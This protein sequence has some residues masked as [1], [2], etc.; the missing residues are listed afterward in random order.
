MTAAAATA[1]GRW[2]GSQWSERCS[3][4]RLVGRGGCRLVAGRLTLPEAERA[5]FSPAPTCVHR[6]GMQHAS[7]RSRLA[8]YVVVW[9]CVTSYSVVRRCESL[10]F[11]LAIRR[12]FSLESGGG[13]K[14]RGF[15]FC[16]VLAIWRS[17]SLEGGGGFKVVQCAAGL[18]GEE[19]AEQ[20]Q[21]CWWGAC[22][23]ALG[24]GVR[25]RVGFGDSR[26]GGRHF[27]CFFFHGWELHFFFYGRMP[28][29]LWVAQVWVFM[30][31]EEKRLDCDRTL[32]RVRR[33]KSCVVACRDACPQIRA[34]R[35][36][37]RGQG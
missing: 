31:Q 29:T 6:A 16:F 32:V 18:Q 10:Y 9:R 33:C 28:S 17:F 12:S 20:Q 34:G 14:E 22:R 26:D 23:Q 15:S 27:F 8:L 37:R 36:Q 30:A 21:N 5:W 7:A 11:V 2:V 13:F 24:G 3:W 25:T 1:A 35:V 4:R 19:D